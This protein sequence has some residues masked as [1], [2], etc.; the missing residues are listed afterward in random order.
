MQ[1]LAQ[2]EIFKTLIS[3]LVYLKADRVGTFNDLPPC[4][5]LIHNFG[6]LVLYLLSLGVNY[7]QL[8]NVVFVVLSLIDPE[9]LQH[10]FIGSILR[11]INIVEAELSLA[12][13]LDDERVECLV[14]LLQR[15]GCRH[16]LFSRV[17][18]G[19]DWRLQCLG[20]LEV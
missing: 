6:N 16:R 12:H 19:R 4:K 15:R 8:L 9:I 13:I 11:V 14:L 7:Q 17:L 1:N 18:R 2:L 5:E 20:H 10:V 3:L